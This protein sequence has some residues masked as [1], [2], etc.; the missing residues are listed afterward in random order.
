MADEARE[1]SLL[2][3]YGGARPPRAA[4]FS[5]A[6]ACAPER[7]SF[8]SAGARIET[9]A[10]GGRGRPGLLFLHGNGAHADW[11]SFIAPYFAATHRCAAISWSG[12]GGSDWRDAYSIT[13][14]ADELLGAIDHAGL[15]DA[16]APIV[17]GHSFGGIPLMYTAVHHTARIGGGILVDSFVPPRERK[18]P[19]WAVSGKP[20]PR[21]ATQAEALARYRFAPPQSSAH[22][23]IVDHIARL[24][25]RDVAADAQGAAGWTWRFDPRMW[26]TIDRSG[27]DPLVENARVPIGLIFGEQSA[28]VSEGHAAT[29]ATRLPDCRFA[30]AVPHARHHIMVDQ[31][32]ALVA[33][34][35]VGVAALGRRT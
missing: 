28:L 21:Y 11:W 4:W 34:L 26:A 3:A 31:P 22:P 13:G 24:S 25:L 1:E 18:A 5:A 6:I 15:A 12:M 17:I 7:S 20:L 35:R 33:A 2:G 27:V 8:D 9:L 32:I 19:G 29:L 10:W 14:F 30:A 23:E 16:G